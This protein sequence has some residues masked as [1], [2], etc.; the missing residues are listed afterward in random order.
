MDAVMRC[1]DFLFGGILMNTKG[2]N[3]VSRWKAIKKYWDYNDYEHE[4]KW[5]NRE[6]HRMERHLSKQEL[7]TEL[8]H[9][10]SPY[11]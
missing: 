1:G 3:N 8:R 2:K 11:C 6:L 4:F 7:K 9:K 5:H 10:N